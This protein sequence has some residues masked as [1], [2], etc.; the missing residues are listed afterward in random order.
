MFIPV[1]DVCKIHGEPQISNSLRPERWDRAELRQ[2]RGGRTLD[3]CPKCAEALQLDFKQP[4]YGE[5]IIDILHDLVN[6][7]LEP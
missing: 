7:A 1:C 4:N 2:Y 6:E 3:F 5:Q